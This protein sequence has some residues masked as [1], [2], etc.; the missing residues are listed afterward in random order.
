MVRDCEAIA[1]EEEEEEESWSGWSQVKEQV[2]N[3]QPR[4]QEETE[5]RSKW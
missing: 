5:K 1:E 4:I 3:N 2:L